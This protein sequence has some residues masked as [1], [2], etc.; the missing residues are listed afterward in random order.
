MKNL[1]FDG[2]ILI[3]INELNLKYTLNSGQ[4]FRWTYDNT[5]NSYYC[6]FYKVLYILK[7][8]SLYILINL[9]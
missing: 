6:A 1:E 2:K 4:C 8:E 5:S 9:F 3:S 7:Q